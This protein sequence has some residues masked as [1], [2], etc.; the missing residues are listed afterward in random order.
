MTG[1]S[2]FILLFLSSFDVTFIS[3]FH[4]GHHPITS[5]PPLNLSPAPLP[6]MLGVQN[7]I[8]PVSR[9]QFPH[10]SSSSDLFQAPPSPKS[11]QSVSSPQVH[12]FSFPSDLSHLNSLYRIDNRNNP[13]PRPANHKRLPLRRSKPVLTVRPPLRRFGVEMP[14]ENLCA[15]PVVSLA[16]LFIPFS[17]GCA[18]PQHTSHPRVRL[19]RVHAKQRLCRTYDLLPF[20]H[21]IPISRQRRAFTSHPSACSQSTIEHAYTH[22]DLPYTGLYF[23]SKGS[24]RPPDLG[25]SGSTRASST[26]ATHPAATDDGTAT[27]PSR[28]M[29]HT[30]P[31][32]LTPAASPALESSAQNQLPNST[33]PSGGTCPG[34]G[35]CNGTGGSSSCS[36]CP[37]YN[38]ALNA[39]SEMDSKTNNQPSPAQPSAEQQQ[40]SADS[41]DGSAGQGA[42]GR[43][44]R[45]APIGA[46]SCANCGTST[47]PLWRRDDVG[48]NICNACGKS[49]VSFN[50]PL[51]CYQRSADMMRWHVLRSRRSKIPY[52][53]GI[54]FF[55]F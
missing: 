37:T 24:I 49:H 52:H 5:P 8:S 3:S 30:P 19:R 29:T 50:L 48:N 6:P 28:H 25:R 47:T 55:W 13:P 12:H 51:R 18:S 23:K 46:L 53:H 27:L 40:Q 36:G 35:V 54:F 31:S 20:P 32:L 44:G 9:L 41:P 45:V 14:R 15:M 10:N 26:S 33:H 2:W 42:R 11:F 43:N 4:S 16:F 21:L 34:D 1:F 38:N 17:R 22:N 7:S 39:G